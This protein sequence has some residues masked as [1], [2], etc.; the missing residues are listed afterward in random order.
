MNLSHKNP[1]YLGFRL[2]DQEMVRRLKVAPALHQGTDLGKCE[3]MLPR[4]LEECRNQLIELQVPVEWTVLGQQ[5]HIYSTSLSKVKPAAP[6]EIAICRV[7]CV[8]VKRE[9]TGQLTR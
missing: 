4:Y 5:T 1:A 2:D 6:G 8:G 7:D 9:S 3:P